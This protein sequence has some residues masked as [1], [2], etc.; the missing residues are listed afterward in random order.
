[1]TSRADDVDPCWGKALAMLRLV[2]GWKQ[3]RL[4][5]AIGVA[6]STVS[7]YESSRAAPM[8]LLRQ[9]VVAMG[10][11]PLFLERA[12]SLARWTTAARHPPG[13]PAPAAG[14]RA[15]MM[16]R[17]TGL[18]AEA[19]V[20][21]ALAAVLPAA[22]GAALH[23][24]ST[25]AA[26]PP[27]LP[28]TPASPGH[29]PHSP[30]VAA[31][32]R[33]ARSTSGGEKPAL[34]VALCILRQVICDL[35]REELADAAGLSCERI[36]TYE[37]AFRLPPPGNLDRLLAA[38]GLPA[39]ALDRTLRFV[40]EAR[41]ARRSRG[42]GAPH[43]REQIA[44][45]AAAEGRR[46]AAAR[47]ALL[48]RLELAASLLDARRRAPAL[49]ARLARYPRVV[50][51][52]LVREVA[53]FQDPGLGELLCAESLRAAGDSARQA[54]GLARLAVLVSERLPGDPGG[55]SRLEGFSRAHLSSALRV[56]GRLMAADRECSRAAE[57]WQA[58]ADAD[59][60]VLNEALVLSLEASLRRDQRRF[61]EAVALLDR[62]LEIDR[63]GT[64]PALLIAKS[65]TL[66]EMG[67][68]DE[69]TALLRQA[70]QL[71][72]PERN[73]RNL[74]LVHLN[75]T[76]NL[77][78]LGEHAAA[79]MNLPKVRELAQRLGNR[80][81]GLRVAWLEARIAA[82]LGEV[83]HAVTVYQRVS[84]GFERQG[85]AYD[86]ALVTLELAELHATLGRTADVK[87]LAREA[88]PI[89]RAERVPREA[90]RAL[91]LFRCA[92]EQ[93][94]ATLDLIRRVGA[95]LQQARRDK[96]LRFQEVA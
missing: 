40:E 12:W 33:P 8:P 18:A 60:G 22:A 21:Q 82:G 17:D 92:A 19:L 95:F 69:S 7:Y 2:C 32:A 72:N 57:R 26:P 53:E 49:W 44:D 9:A 30:M 41:A 34:A 3:G 81:D 86:A 42:H 88:V 24:P 84:A 27:P 55:R 83:E 91:E 75:L 64:T 47:G 96:N 13:G 66:A 20:R 36:K 71:I 16:A 89:F 28:E 10:F 70:M 52:A 76:F 65:K 48:G 58:G 38:M 45:L 94:R 14:A 56:G 15:E 23:A 87:A 80:L 25:A 35:D 90:R 77:C 51:R 59:P 85:I 79:K 63:W 5:Q 78:D 31:A 54:L 6:H 1:M 67:D 11:P 50:R 46:S 73:T 93:E 37:L 68:L 43:Q 4:G 29:R 61:A 39:E 74:F 62:A